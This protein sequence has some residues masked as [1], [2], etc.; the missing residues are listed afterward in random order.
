VKRLLS[1]DPGL[2]TGVAL[3]EYGPEKPYTLL[4]AVQI[5]DGL[6]GFLEWVRGPCRV[7]EDRYPDLLVVAE[8]FTP[9]NHSDYALTTESVEPLRIEGA[10]VA[11]GLM[12]DTPDERWRRP[13]EMYFVGGAD[14]ADKKKRAHALLK[15]VG[16][17]VTG[18]MVGCRDAN[19][20]RSAIL[21]GIAYVMKVEKH[22]PTWE[23][24]SNWKGGDD[25]GQPHN[26]M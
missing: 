10:M 23:L 18:K 13:A 19:D 12:P 25:G 5:E 6:S 4:S 9:I 16:M 21:H 11:L 15:D 3:G 1:I 26:T 7:I 14:L 17:R 8:K 20:V 2:S 22:R 24:V